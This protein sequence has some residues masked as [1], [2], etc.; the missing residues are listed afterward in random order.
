MDDAYLRH[1]VHEFLKG[2]REGKKKLEFHPSTHR[3]L[4]T[5]GTE[6]ATC[7]FSHVP[8]P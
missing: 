5:L 6:S 8:G 1:L 7:W 4:Q 2:T 3:V